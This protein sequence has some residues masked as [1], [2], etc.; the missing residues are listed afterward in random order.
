M[1]FPLGY[2]LHFPDCQL[3]MLFFF[4]RLLV[5]VNAVLLSVRFCCLLLKR[6]EV[7]FDRRLNF[8]Y[9]RLILLRFFFFFTKVIVLFKTFYLNLT[10]IYKS[11]NVIGVLLEDRL[12]MELALR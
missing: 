10:H 9:I 7:Y 2:G 11:T 3:L 8:L 12:P 5:T 4:D 6:V 1:N